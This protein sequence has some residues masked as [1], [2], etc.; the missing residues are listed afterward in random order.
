MTSSARRGFQSTRRCGCTETRWS[1]QSPAERG[2]CRSRPLSGGTARSPS[3]TGS[4]RCARQGSRPDCGCPREESRPE[5]RQDAEGALRQQVDILHEIA[6]Q[7]A[8]DIASQ[9]GHRAYL[10]GELQRARS[11]TLQSAG[12]PNVDEF[13]AEIATERAEVERL[14]RELQ[15]WRNDD[16]GESFSSRRAPEAQREVDH[17]LQRRQWII[18][19]ERLERAVADAHDKVQRSSSA[20][21]ARREAD[22]R[23]ATTAE[24]HVSW[25]QSELAAERRETSLSEDRLT[26]VWREVEQERQ[27]LAQAQEELYLQG[28]REVVAVLEELRMVE[29]R[30]EVEGDLQRAQQAQLQ[31]VEAT[32]AS[33]KEQLQ[34]AQLDNSRLALSLER[35]HRTASA[36]STLCDREV[37]RDRTRPMEFTDRKSVV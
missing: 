8:E 24:V 20:A 26:A 15:I 18:E 31:S 13:A 37:T 2:L 29:K 36:I 9:K 32:I 35:S 34:Q 21:A 16:A 27:V 17:E 10:R 25:L 3:R 4:C 11:D 14:R 19:K 6:R 22:R 1:S 28:E 7:Q 33:L 30:L 12:V 23:D 5:A